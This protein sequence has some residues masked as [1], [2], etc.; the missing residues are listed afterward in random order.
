MALCLKS[1]IRLS[2][3]TQGCSNAWKL[4]ERCIADIKQR[5]NVIVNPNT[6]GDGIFPAFSEKQ[7]FKKETF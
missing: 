3:L 6:A 1:V 5:G 7:G 4:P 2:I